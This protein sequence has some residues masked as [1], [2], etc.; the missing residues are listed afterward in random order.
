M[1]RHGPK[2]VNMLIASKATLRVTERT[3][4]HLFHFSETLQDVEQF[5]ASVL[6]FDSHFVASQPFWSAPEHYSSSRMLERSF[7]IMNPLDLSTVISE[8]PFERLWAILVIR[9]CSRS[10][11]SDQMQP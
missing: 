5:V 10:S 11:S 6:P 1:F 9:R 4:R 2:L 3:L 8:R 7:G